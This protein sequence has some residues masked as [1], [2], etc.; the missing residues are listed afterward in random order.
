[1]ESAAAVTAVEAPPVVIRPAVR[2]KRRDVP[3]VKVYSRHTRLCKLTKDTKTACNCP[4][5]LVFW[6]DGKLH[7]VSA[8]TNDRHAAEQKARALENNF[9]AAAKGQPTTSPIKSESFLIGDLVDTGKTFLLRAL[10]VLLHGEH[11]QVSSAISDEKEVENQLVNNAFVVFDDA[12]ALSAKVLALLRRAVTGG[13]MQRRELYSTSRQ[14][15]LPYIATVAVTSSKQPFHNEEDLNRQITFTIKKRAGG[16]VDEEALIKQ[17]FAARTFFMN[18]MIVRVKLVIRAIEVGKNDPQ[19]RVPNR[20]AGVATL[21]INMMKLPDAL[22][23]EEEARLLLEN[24]KRD[25]ESSVM[26]NNDLAESLIAWMCKGKFTAGEEL[27]AGELLDRLTPYVSGKPNWAESGWHLSNRLLQV[28]SAFEHE[29]G[30]QTRK[31]VV[32][33]YPTGASLRL[34]GNSIGETLSPRASSPSTT[35]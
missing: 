25:Q 17:L 2:R 14:V 19:V 5:S 16:N 34:F 15:E 24:W 1:M 27:T 11:F 18:S 20:L 13:K 23:G 31:R 32:A 7:R 29:L 26:S 8:E 12:D 28:T 6:R 22:T 9:E 4:K 3:K 33:A 21:I 10:G 30:M 35:T